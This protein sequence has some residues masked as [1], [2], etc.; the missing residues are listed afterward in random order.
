LGPEEDDVEPEI[1][2][3]WI[4]GSEIREGEITWKGRRVILMYG[5]EGKLLDPKRFPRLQARLRG[6]RAQLKKRSIVQNGAPWYRTI[7]RVRAETW[8]RPK[9]LLPEIAKIPR[10]AIDL[11]GAVPSHGVYAIF[12]GDDDVMR[13]YE[14]LKNG[15]LASALSNI[16]PKIGSDFVRCYKRFLML[17]RV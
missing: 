16:A 4:D 9:L 10:V 11:S 7:D 8:A 14:K 15:K 12:A 5:S 6:F 1:L 3:P 17:A 2:H 13:I